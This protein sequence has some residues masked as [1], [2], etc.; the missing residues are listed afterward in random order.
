MSTSKSIKM[1]VMHQNLN[2]GNENLKHFIFLSRCSNGAG[3][4]RIMNISKQNRANTNEF[5]LFFLNNDEGS[6]IPRLR[7]IF[8]VPATSV[9]NTIRF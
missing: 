6:I 8:D 7:D 9:E 5:F 3:N 1:S 2:D 4:A